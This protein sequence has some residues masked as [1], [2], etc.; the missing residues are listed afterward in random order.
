MCN[1]KILHI[2][3]H[4]PSEMNAYMNLHR[5]GSPHQEPLRDPMLFD[6]RLTSEGRHKAEALQIQIAA[7]ETK[8]PKIYCSPLTRCLET[9]TLAFKPLNAEIIALP[10]LRERLQLSSEVGR[11]FEELKADFPDVNFELFMP[12]S[13]NE[14]WW[15]HENING[16]NKDSNDGIIQEPESVYLERLDELRQL[17][18]DESA[19]CLALVSHWG[20]LKHLTDRDLDLCELQTSVVFDY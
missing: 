4:G 3:R 5:Y 11:P 6:A 19:E 17:L 8:P 14:P 12:Q 2:L 20:V 16:I 15:Y 13:N 18:A 7:L 1:Q 10:L 9:A